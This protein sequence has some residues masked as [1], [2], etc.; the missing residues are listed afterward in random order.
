MKFRLLAMALPGAFLGVS[1]AGCAADSGPKEAGGTLVGA[2][3]GALIGN[4]IGGAAGNRAAG[5]IAGAAIG[6]LIGN[7][8][9]A[10]MDDEDKRRAYEAQMQA[11][12]AG[13]SGAPVAWR[14]PDSGR[15]GSVVPGAAYQANGMNCRPYTH[16]IYIDGRPQTTR[17]TACRNPDGTWTAL[18][19]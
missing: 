15:Y 18:Q 13:P 9:G 5:T 4:A 1:L 11:L 3:A 17:G 16:T 7:R 14:N 8:V 6:G 2:G 10:A 12:E 19:G